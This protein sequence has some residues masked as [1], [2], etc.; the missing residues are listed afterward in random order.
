MDGCEKMN[1]KEKIEKV[2]MRVQKPARY[3]GGELNSVIKDREKVDVRFAFCFP[4]TYEIGMSHLGIKILYHILNSRENVWCERVFAPWF[5]MKEEMEKENI[6]LYALESLDPVSDFDIIGFTL[7]YELCYTNVLYM[8]ELAGIPL[9]SRERK[10]LKN[11]VVGGGP[12][13]CNPEP[14]ADFFDLFMLGDGEDVI[15]ELCDLYAE[16]K[17]KGSDKAAF[18]ADAAKIPGIYVPSFYDVTYNED[19]TVKEIA[20][21]RP[22]VPKK[23]TKR[24]VK[25]F[26]KTPYPDSFVVSFI[27]TVHDRAVLEVLRGC[28]RGCRFCQAGFI[29][30]PFREKSVETLCRQAKELCQN[31]GYDEISLCS[32]STSD[33]TEIER[34]LS[35]LT[36]WSD[37]EKISL[38]LPS[39]R[40]DNFSKEVLDGISGIRKS[41]L[42]FAPEAGTQ[43]L[44]DVINK[45]VTA[46]ELH[47]TCRIAFEGG[48]TGIKLY[49]MI[50]L[51]TETDEDIE[52]IINTAQSVVNLFYSLENRPK[53]SGVTVTVSVATFVPKPHTPSQWEAQDSLETV[54]R[55]HEVLK[56]VGRSKKITL[57][58]HASNTSILEG[59]FARGDRKI[60]QAIYEAYK[61]GAYFD[62][63][64]EG[65][66]F[67]KW[68]AAFDKCGLS[69]QFYQGRH[70]PF[71]EVLPWSHIDFGVTKAFL[72][73]EC[74]KAYNAETTGHCR[75]VCSGCGANKF[76]GGQC[77]AEH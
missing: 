64:S 28:I 14:V 70:R 17:K 31:T 12:C 22:E 49:F 51:P 10:E 75:K 41:G 48:Y 42:T 24:V 68:Q 45:N 4:D 71:D 15:V 44:R 39:L 40:V 59:V 1:L 33:H 72:E 9:Y 36:E 20:P 52:G 67:D 50:G 35:E 6:P 61:N 21:N 76:A 16:H 29:Y 54:I 26:D 46:E 3:I 32:L 23:I 13:A 47:N 66:D 8:L 37:K 53:G 77:S 11:L 27:E 63:W 19:K 65:F 69:M 56:S 7:Q 62:S 55:K 30:R 57:N 74:K 2:I 58:Y 34:M 38:S 18:L 60:G 25:D 43:R 73:R 5:D